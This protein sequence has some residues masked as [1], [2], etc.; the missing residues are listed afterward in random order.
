MFFSRRS[1][2]AFRMS[3]IKYAYARHRDSYLWFH[4]LP[5]LRR[6]LPSL[7]THITPPLRRR[8]PGNGQVGERGKGLMFECLNVRMLET[9]MDFEGQLLTCI[10]ALYS[11]ASGRT[12][13]SSRNRQR[14]FL[15][16]PLPDAACEVGIHRGFWRRKESLSARQAV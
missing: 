9:T 12:A 7:L 4:I 1:G 5:L 3:P 8:G 13:R 11:E 2:I 16:G 15:H 10:R 6:L 14:E